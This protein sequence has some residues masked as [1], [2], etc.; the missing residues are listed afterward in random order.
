MLTRFFDGFLAILPGII[1]LVGISAIVY[2]WIKKED[3]NK[4][5]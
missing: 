5:K 4:D 2:W 3:K 1:I